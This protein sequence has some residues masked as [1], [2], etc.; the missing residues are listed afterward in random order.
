[1]ARIDLGPWAAALAGLPVDVQIALYRQLSVR[2][3]IN[4]QTVYQRPLVAETASLAAAAG[5]TATGSWRW[6]TMTCI[7]QISGSQDTSGINRSECDL[8]IQSQNGSYPW[9][10]TS[11]LPV[12]L[13]AIADVSTGAQA[14]TRLVPTV[15]LRQETWLCTLT[16]N[17]SSGTTALKVALKGVQLYSPGGGF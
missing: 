9:I 14:Y 15:A 13:A 2:R 8:Q 3:D 5:G 11:D 17:A 1:M 16:N 12:S 10:G 4:A 6:Q 7:Y